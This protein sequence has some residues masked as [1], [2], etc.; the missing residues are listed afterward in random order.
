[1]ANFCTQC[2]NP[3]QPATRFCTACGAQLQRDGSGEPAPVAF[4][5]KR[6]RVLGEAPT[7]NSRAP[8]A[9]FFG[10]AG[11]LALFGGLTFFN[12][13]PERGN[14]GNAV[15]A[16]QPAV[17]QPAAYPGTATNM[18]PIPVAVA[19]GSITL[20]LDQVQAKRFVAFEYAS[21]RGPIPLLAYITGEGKVVTA[22]SMCEPCNSTRFH[23]K[24]DDLICNSCG[25]TWELD[26]LAGLSGACQDYP[27]DAVPNAIVGNEIRIEEAVVA[28]W[29]PRQ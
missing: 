24:G 2:G 18:V 10:L 6:A 3:I 28:A 16:A 9:I 19:N 22:V 14:A 27:P 5:E 17:V 29:T 20:P 15:I 26:N 21:A 1:M 4:A 11:L 25:T 12:S 7:G 8:R 23:I 13:M